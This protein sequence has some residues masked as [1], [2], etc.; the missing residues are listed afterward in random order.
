[1]ADKKDE[2]DGWEL[3]VSPLDRWPGKF[4]LPPLDDFNGEHWAVWRTAVSEA[5]GDNINRLYCYAGL[6]LIDSLGSWQINTPIADII[7]WQDDPK[8]ERMRL[9]GWLGRSMNGYI[10]ELIDPKG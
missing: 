9:V 4:L 1:M 8:A 5:P 7:K 6:R 10:N 2:F 3:F